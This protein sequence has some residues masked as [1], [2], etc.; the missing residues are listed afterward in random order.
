METLECV[1]DL[2]SCPCPCGRL[3][4]GK[5]DDD[6]DSSCALGGRGDMGGKR[7]SGV[8]RIRD[9]AVFEADGAEGPPVLLWDLF[10]L[11]AGRLVVDRSGEDVDSTI[12]GWLSRVASMGDTSGI[13]MLGTPLLDLTSR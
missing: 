13:S 4:V 5:G 3:N 2:R 9:R 10:R 6:A 8:A 1:G 7:K 12:G 11:A